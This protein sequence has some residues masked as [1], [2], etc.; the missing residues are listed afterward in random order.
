MIIYQDGSDCS[1]PG[2][3]AA[4]EAVSNCHGANRLG[5]NSILDIVV[6]GKAIAQNI[7]K[8]NKPGEKQPLLKDVSDV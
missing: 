4:G 6:F 7:G 8:A 5:A 2:L 1:V 3:Y